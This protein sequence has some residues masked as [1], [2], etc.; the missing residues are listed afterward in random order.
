MNISSDARP[1]SVHVSILDY[2]TG[3]AKPRTYPDR[4]PTKE[5]TKDEASAAAAVLGF[6]SL[7]GL[8]SGVVGFV[9]YDG[10]R[11]WGQALLP[12]SSLSGLGLDEPKISESD[13]LVVFGNY[14]LAKLDGQ[15]SNTSDV[16]VQVIELCSDEAA[17]KHRLAW[18][19]GAVSKMVEIVNQ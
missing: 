8:N 16:L 4:V 3:F 5:Q 9:E 12:Q 10:S 19:S 7:C 2:S 14:E 11:Y 18:A 15:H 1:C 13:P 17:D 6:L